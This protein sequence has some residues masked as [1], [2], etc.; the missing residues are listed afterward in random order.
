M[1]QL[2]CSCLTTKHR[3]IDSSC[4]SFQYLLNILVYSLLCW[5]HFWK[6]KKTPEN[7]NDVLWIGKS[8]EAIA[9]TACNWCTLANCQICREIWW[10]SNALDLPV[11]LALDMESK[12]LQAWLWEWTKGGWHWG[13]S[14]AASQGNWKAEFDYI[15][16][17]VENQIWPSPVPWY[18]TSKVRLPFRTSCWKTDILYCMGWWKNTSYN[19]RKCCSSFYQNWDEKHKHNF[20]ITSSWLLVSFLGCFRVK[21]CRCPVDNYRMKVSKILLMF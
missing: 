5:K 13:D 14:T 17:H 9:H 19:G 12:T 6:K 3:I 20:L 4:P 8:S 10:L 11:H 7:A 21:K 18:F 16:V 15:A 2:C 1:I